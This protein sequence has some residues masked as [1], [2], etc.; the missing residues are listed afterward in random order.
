MIRNSI[1][2][3]KALQDVVGRRLQNAELLL[4][5]GLLRLSMLDSEISRLCIE[6]AEIS[7]AWDEPSA[8][9]SIELRRKMA[10][11]RIDELKA[12]RLVADAECDRLRDETRGLLRRKIALDAAI[13]DLEGEQRRRLRKT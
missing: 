13:D 11:A 10:A 5:A 1:R 7:S 3:A 6:R 4:S 9:A 2:Q 8:M 12:A